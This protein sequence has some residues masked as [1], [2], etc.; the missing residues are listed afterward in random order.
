MRVRK[1]ARGNA[2]K[3]RLSVYKTNAHISAQ[4]IDDELGVTIASVGT[5]HKKFKETEFGRKSKQAAR[6]LGTV[7]AGMAKEKSIEAVVFDR[8]RYKFHG[9]IAELATGAREAGL[10]F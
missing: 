6:H 3:P 8:G 1:G 9:I 10:R 4:L 2:A 7:L 5:H